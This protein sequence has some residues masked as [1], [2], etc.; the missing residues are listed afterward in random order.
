MRFVVIIIG[1]TIL[2]FLAY[3]WTSAL[4]T[5]LVGEALWKGGGLSPEEAAEV[6]RNINAYYGIWFALVSG[7]TIAFYGLAHSIE[8]NKKQRERDKIKHNKEEEDKKPEE[9][10]SNKEKA[11]LRAR[12]EELEED[13]KSDVDSKAEDYFEYMLCPFCAERIKAKAIKCR[14]CH[15]F[16]YEK[17]E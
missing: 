5:I 16:L 3:E 7:A 14:Y 12:L 1:L 10:Y 8:K 13:N 2:G 6:R 11:A 9:K 4:D 17:G 15:S